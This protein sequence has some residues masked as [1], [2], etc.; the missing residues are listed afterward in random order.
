MNS[1]MVLDGGLIP[2]TF[3]DKSGIVLAAFDMNPADVN[4]AARCEEVSKF[5]SEKAKNIGDTLED[6]QTYDKELSEKLNYILG[7]GPDYQL[8]KPPMSATTILPS[9]DLFATV[10]F[11]KI[12]EVVQPEIRKRKQAMSNAAKKYVDKYTK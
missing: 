1:N 6:A 10:I 3:S 9:G 8:F 2:F 4:V 12:V 7:Y 5:F 11:E